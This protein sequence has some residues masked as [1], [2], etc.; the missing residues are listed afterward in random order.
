MSKDLKLKIIVKKSSTSDT[1]PMRC[2][3]GLDNGSNINSYLPCE[4]E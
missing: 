1:I 2:T 3:V 4:Y